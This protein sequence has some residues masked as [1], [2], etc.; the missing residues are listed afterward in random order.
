MAMARIMRVVLITLGSSKMTCLMEQ[1]PSLRKSSVFMG[2]LW[3]VCCRGEGESGRVGLLLMVVII[4]ARE[5][6]VISMVMIART[7]VGSSKTSIMAKAL[8]CSRTTYSSKVPSKMVN[9]TAE[10]RW[11]FKVAVNTREVSKTVIMTATG[12]LRGRMAIFIEENTEQE[13]TKVLGS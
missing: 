2:N 3:M 5:R 12:S 13:S 7:R 6:R 9:S 11:L 8:S 1:E 4:R 10:G